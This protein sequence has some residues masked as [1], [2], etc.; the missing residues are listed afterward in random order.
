M[1]FKRKS[2][3]ILFFVSSMAIL[4]QGIAKVDPFEVTL[5]K[6][7]KEYKNEVNFVK[8]FLFYN[9]KKWDSTLIYSMKQ[10]SA[11]K[12]RELANYCRFFRGKSF[13]NLDLFKQAKRELH[14]VSKDFEFYLLANNHLGKVLIESREFKEALSIFKE[15]ESLGDNVP[16]YIDKCLLYSDIGTCYLFLNDFDNSEKYFL[17]AIKLAEK[18]NDD[19]VLMSLYQ[20]IANVYYEQYKDNKAIPYFEKAYQLSKR[21]DDFSCKEFSAKNMAVVEQN[22]NNFEKALEY[23]KEYD[24]WKDS[25]NNQNKIWETAQIE[26]KFAIKQ[27]QKEVNLLATE[28]KLREAERNSLLFSS[29]L[30][31]VILGAGFYFYRQKVKSNKIILEQKM[32]LDDLNATKDKLFSIVSHDL[33]SSVNALKTS[34]SKLQTSLSSKNYEALDVQLNTNNAI[35]NG[36]YNLLD[37]LLNWALL[38]TQQSFFYQES[39]HLQSIVKQVVFNYEPLMLNKGISFQSN[40]AAPIFVFVDTDSF[41]IILRNLLDNAIKFCSENGNISVYTRPSDDHFC[42]LVV[43]DSGLGMTE[44]KRQEL[45]APTVLLSKKGKEEG[46]GTGL[47]MQLC[48]SLIDKN[49]GTFAIETKLNQGTKMIIG[50]PLAIKL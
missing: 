22:R 2:F 24:Q 15:I 5:R 16:S 32:I 33:R 45:L 17:T 3:L 18:G 14:L 37:N 29:G 36:A 13:L 38:Q 12:N 50:L 34:N 35:A 30:L 41:K 10:L 20:N 19:K 43:E 46:V 27:K 8:A 40:V 23:R 49:G 7:S 9:Q 48:K 11:N 44:T 28:N 1:T 21:V 47:G 26:K 4:S 39:A 42:Y 25:L 6:K 31:L